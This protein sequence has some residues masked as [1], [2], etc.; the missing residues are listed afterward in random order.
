MIKDRPT[1]L[2]NQADY[3]SLPAKPFRV[4][5][6]ALP[7]MVRKSLGPLNGI[8][9]VTG[10]MF[11]A[12]NGTL[13]D[14]PS[15]GEVNLFRKAD[16]RFQSIFVV[17][18][19]AH[20]KTEGETLTAFPYALTLIPSSKRGDIDVRT[21][22]L[23]AKLDTQKYLAEAEPCYVAFNPFMGSWSMFGPLS[24]FLNR[25]KPYDCFLDELGVVVGQYFLTTQ[26]DAADVLEA[27]IGLG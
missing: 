16:T 3:K 1:H 22:D 10:A 20:L 6:E 14:M 19:I 26:Y 23:V 24:L 27:P 4:K 5:F 12:S 21:I 25:E 18:S 13:R 11:K 2:L 17:M 7:E 8:Q 15:E 9:P